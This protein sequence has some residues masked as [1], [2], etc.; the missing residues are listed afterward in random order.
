[1]PQLDDNIGLNQ[2]RKYGL[3]KEY[4]EARNYGLTILE[5]LEEWDLIDDDLIS[6]FGHFEDIKK[7]VRHKYLK[8]AWQFIES[9]FSR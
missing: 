4:E 8:K 2:A 9:V 3:E 6:K 5:A 1:M 7:P